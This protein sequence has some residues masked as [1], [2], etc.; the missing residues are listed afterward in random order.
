MDVPREQKCGAHPLL[1]TNI[2]LWLKY[3]RHNAKECNYLCQHVFPFILVFYNSLEL[4][5]CNVSS[6]FTKTDLRS[7]LNFQMSKLAHKPYHPQHPG[8]QQHSAN[9]SPSC[10][11]CSADT[12]L[13]PG[14]LKQRHSFRDRPITGPIIFNRFKSHG[15]KL[16][17]VHLSGTG[18][19]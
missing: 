13:C 3:N 15:W 6:L 2:E 11:W 8:M 17:T 16:L 9:A 4:H 14:N 7:K 12:R 1:F 10:L 18:K 19:N 5:S